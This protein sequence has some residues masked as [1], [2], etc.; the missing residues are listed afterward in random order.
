MYGAVVTHDEADVADV[1]RAAVAEGVRTFFAAF[2]SGSDS[3]SRL[4][5]PLMGSA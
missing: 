4:R 2:I 1:D 3:A 5:P